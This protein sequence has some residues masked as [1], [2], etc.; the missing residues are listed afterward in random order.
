MARATAFG[1]M[2]TPSRFL[3]SA[4]PRGRPPPSM[5]SVRA[6]PPAG[7]LGFGCAH[8]FEGLSILILYEHTSTVVRCQPQGQ[9]TTSRRRSRR[10]VVSP[11][12]RRRALRPRRLSCRFLEGLN[13]GC[14][15]A[16]R[17]CAEGWATVRFPGPRA[18]QENDITKRIQA[19]VAAS[20]VRPRGGFRQ[21]PGSWNTL[22]RE[23][24]VPSASECWRG[25]PQTYSR[26]D[27]LGVRVRGSR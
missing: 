14:A 27:M 21:T 7:G 13:G 12:A 22:S 2:P 6:L 18:P 4:G 8:P 20:A 5:T 15:P 24:S 10:R 9:A 11:D 19:F 16:R 1:V 17:A 3:G 26:Q 25:T 23:I